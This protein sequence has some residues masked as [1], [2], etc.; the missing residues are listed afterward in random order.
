MTFLNTSLIRK[1]TL[2]LA[3]VM[4]PVS[5]MALD[6]NQAQ[7]LANQGY[8]DAQFNLGMMRYDGQGKRK[9]YIRSSE[10]YQNT[11]D[12]SDTRAHK[13]FAI[14]VMITKVCVS[15]ISKQLICIR[16]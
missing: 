16:K 6:F 13:V 7:G 8:S 14:N 4:I 15:I 5:A 11:A 1:T 2:F 10:L 12:Q 3:A 9:N